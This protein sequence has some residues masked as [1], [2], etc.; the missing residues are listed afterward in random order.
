MALHAITGAFGFTGSYI[1]K[2]LL[3]AGETVVTLTNSPDRASPLKGRLTAY[4]FRFDNVDLM[5]ESLAGADVL[6]NTYWVRFNQTGLFS[7]DEAVR[8]TQA[9]FEAAKRAGVRRLVHVSISNA[10]EASPLEYFQGKGRL[11]RA[12][13]ASGMSYAVVRPAVLFGPEDIL[14]NNIAWTLRHFPVF[15]LFGD[16][17]YHI[18][19]IYVDDLA[20]LM[21]DRG[22]AADNE[23]INALGPEDFTYGELVAMIRDSLGLKR[24]IIGVPPVLAYWLGRAVGA[25]VGDV[26]VTR[27][28]IQGLMADTLHV[29][30]DAP[31]G[32]TRLSDWVRLHKETIGRNYHGEMP[33]RKDR[34]KAY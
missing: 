19:P 13:H 5:A 22:R 34:K 12:L 7:H 9:L 23:V 18:Q 10:D 28:E 21:I 27:E 2:R 16:G 31:A 15:A 8:N 1:A 14:I 4:P 25:L 11:E 17:R 29:A 24:P 33:R 3:D 30:G 20:A 6:Y 32:K 26:F